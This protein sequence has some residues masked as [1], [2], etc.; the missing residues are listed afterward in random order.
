M[1]QMARREKRYYVVLKGHKTGIFNNWY[2]DD[3]AEVQ[4]NGFPGARFKGFYTLKEARDWLSKFNT[5]EVESEINEKTTTPVHS[6]HNK[7]EDVKKERGGKSKKE[8]IGKIKKETDERDLKSDRRVVIYT[9]GSCIKNPGPGGYGVVLIYKDH[10]REM[11]GGFRLTTNNRMELMGCIVALDMLKYRC[12][13]SIYTDSQYVVKGF[14][15]GWARRWRRRGWMKNEFEPAENADLWE[16]LLNLSDK[17][18]VEF[19]WIKGHNENL[20]NEYCDVMAKRAASRAKLPL[21]IAYENGS[22]RV[23][24][25][26]RKK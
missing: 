16:R 2:G 8:N 15:K 18:D 23:K 20:E 3:G 1:K 17:H 14:N 6:F 11:Y 13:V 9:D 10:R 24:S 19:I 21:D 4:V 25:N 7:A 12:S 26:N 22:T 5:G